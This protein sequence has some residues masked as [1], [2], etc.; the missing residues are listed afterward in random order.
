MPECF[1]IYGLRDMIALFSGFVVL[2][3]FLSYYAAE[4]EYL[5]ATGQLVPKE[6]KSKK[7]KKGDLEENLN[8]DAQ[9]NQTNDANG[10]SDNSQQNKTVED[11]EDGDANSLSEDS[12]QNQTNEV[13]EDGNANSLNENPQQNKTVEDGEG[14]DVPVQEKSDKEVR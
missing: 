12:Q 2:M 8:E 11:G 9:Q 1:P 4:K 6:R 14:T 13:G 10:L 5:Y 7:N 3:V